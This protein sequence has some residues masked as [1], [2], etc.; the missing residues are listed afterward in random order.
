MVLLRDVFFIMFILFC[1]YDP[2]DVTLTSRLSN[3][4]WVKVETLTDT[5][6]TKEYSVF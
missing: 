6:R 5:A 3:T 4:N 2:I 1:G